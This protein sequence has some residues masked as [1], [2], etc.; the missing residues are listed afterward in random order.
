MSRMRTYDSDFAL[1]RG[2]VDRVDGGVELIKHTGSADEK[3]SSSPRYWRDDRH[4]L[5]TFED[6]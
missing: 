6:K 4:F 5:S 3:T 2:L 1:E